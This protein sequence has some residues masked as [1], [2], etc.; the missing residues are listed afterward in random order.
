MGFTDGMAV[1]YAVGISDG[2]T[3]GIAVG[4]VVGM[5]D[6]AAV[7]MRLGA[8]VGAGDG[9]EVGTSVGSRQMGPPLRRPRHMQPRLSQQ[10]FFLHLLHGGSVGI[11]VGT[12]VGAE[13]APP[14]CN[15][16]RR[17]RPS[18]SA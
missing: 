4:P 3:V 8:A 1:G 11:V 6:G 15:D 5:S 14:A 16:L 17:G 10:P 13:S 18:L 12:G 9:K 7:G 2:A